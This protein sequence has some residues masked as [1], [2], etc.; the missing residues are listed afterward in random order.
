LNF[1]GDWWKLYGGN[2][3]RMAPLELWIPW[4]CMKSREKDWFGHI[5]WIK[6]KKKTKVFILERFRQRSV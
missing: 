4:S 6:V 1:E 5:T 2:V 3:S